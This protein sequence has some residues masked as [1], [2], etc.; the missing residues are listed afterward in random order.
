MHVV[1]SPTFGEVFLEVFLG[2]VEAQVADKDSLG[3]GVARL[4]CTR[5]IL[6][7]FG[8]VRATFV[9]VCI[10]DEHTAASHELLA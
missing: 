1:N 6:L 3:G 8:F 7:G 10:F 2:H 9:V 5:G 4:G